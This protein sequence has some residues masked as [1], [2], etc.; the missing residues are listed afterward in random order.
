MTLG[1]KFLLSFALSLLWGLP[2]GYGTVSATEMYRISPQEL[3]QLE[4]NLNQLAESNR[5]KQKLLIEQD[6]QLTEASQQLT[7]ANKQLQ[8]ANQEI[9]KSKTQNEAMKLSLEKANQYLNEYE[10]EMKHKMKVKDRQLRTCK[11]GITILAGLVVYKS[12]K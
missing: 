2:F 7:E 12:V 4:T 11:L 8:I 10:K 5:N 6:K 3:N 9:E 1:R